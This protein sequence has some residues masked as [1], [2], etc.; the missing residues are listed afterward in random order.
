MEINPFKTLIAQIVDKQGR[1]VCV[2]AVQIFHVFLQ[3]PMHI[4]IQQVPIQAFREIPFDPLPEF[5]AHEQQFPSRM[6][7]H[8]AVQ[9]PQIGE[10]LPHVAGHLIEQRAF[11]MHDFI[12]RQNKHETFVERIQQG[13]R[14]HVMMIAP[15]NR[16]FRHIDEHVV[17]PAHVP[18]EHEAQASEM[19]GVRHARP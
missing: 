17:H 2:Q 12:M 11:A 14:D 5:A 15:M 4:I 7:V 8:E 9:R 16:V 18:F 6:A 19:H 13:K 3:L 1:F 10:F